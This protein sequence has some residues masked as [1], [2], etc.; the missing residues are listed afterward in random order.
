MPFTL[1]PLQTVEDALRHFIQEMDLEM[2]KMLL[3]GLPEEN[4]GDHV[5]L[6]FQL[7]RAFGYFKGLGDT[8]LNAIQG[9]CM[10]CF[11]TSKGFIFVSNK[12][13]S[14]LYLLFHHEASGILSIFECNR[15]R[16]SFTFKFPG[17][18]VYL[19]DTRFNQITMRPIN[20]D[21]VPF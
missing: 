16:S 13:K 4:P 7:E 5:R 14:Y 18:R 6:F 1:R 11:P 12:S 17:K 15:L 20:D 8:H 19:D 9:K 21:D 10:R 3:G 2:V